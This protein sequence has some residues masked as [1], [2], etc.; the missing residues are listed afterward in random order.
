MAK[1]QL[2][3]FAI[4]Q[5]ATPGTAETLTSSDV[6]VK[7]RSG[8]TWGFDHEIFDH[9][10]VQSTSSPTAVSIGR[11]LVNFDIEYLLRG[12][13]SQTTDPAIVDMWEAAMLNGAEA[14]TI[15]VGTITGTYTIGET[16]T[17]G[18]SSATGRVLKQASGSDGSI[19]FISL[20][21]TF[22]S[23]ETVTGGSSGATSTSSGAPAAGGYAFQFEDN[24]DF[25][26]GNHVTCQGVLSD[27]GEFTGRGA[28]GNIAFD[29]E[30]CKPVVVRQSF[31]GALSS[32]TDS[33]LYSPASFP[34]SSVT[35]PKAANVGMIFGS[36]SPTGIVNW[37]LNCPIAVEPILDA[38]SSAADCVQYM[39]YDRRNNPPTITIAPSWVLAATYDYFGTLEAETTF[40]LQWEIG[41]TAGST[42]TFAAPAAQF[43]SLQL[44]ERSPDHVEIQAEIRLTGTNND[45]LF[46]W[47][48]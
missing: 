13:A 17:G 2:R 3:E 10:E 33:S 39:D 48:H 25:S 22:Q 41:S 19:G 34:E 35:P 6:L 47:Q 14:N 45:E 42:W 46:I 4:E 15:A 40:A 11:K 24:N 16:I 23:G 12:P 1:Y 32:H 31:T 8:T 18:T 44:G 29:F 27:G 5:E 37:S 38:N 26:A 30:N 20:S 9:D 28:L 43:T 36:Y 21:G 7:L